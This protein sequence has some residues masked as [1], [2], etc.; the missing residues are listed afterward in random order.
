[1][2]TQEGSGGGGGGWGG[3]GYNGGLATLGQ[4]QTG[5]DVLTINRGGGGGG[6]CVQAGEIAQTNRGGN[7]GNGCQVNI[8]GSLKYYAAGGGAGGYSTAITFASTG[9]LGGGGIG[10]AYFGNGT[11]ATGYGSGG[12]AGSRAGEFVGGGAGSDGIVIIRYTNILPETTITLLYPTNNQFTS[13]DPVPINYTIV[14]ENPIDTIQL[15]I[16]GTLNKTVSGNQNT[17][18]DIGEGTFFLNV[19]ANN[20]NGTIGYDTALFT[21]DRTNPFDNLLVQI[22]PGTLYPDNINITIQAD[23]VNLD[24]R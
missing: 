7:G 23:N 19:S 14:S 4:G 17:T 13:K 9:G 5:G 21:V 6:G 18:I 20:T 8:T 12:G 1:M 15:F 24:T 22:P 11:D 3:V 10:P 2:A 16:N